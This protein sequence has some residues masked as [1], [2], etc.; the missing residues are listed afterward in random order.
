MR[1]KQTEQFSH[2][3]CGSS[4]TWMDELIAKKIHIT[5]RRSPSSFDASLSARDSVHTCEVTLDNR[6]NNHSGY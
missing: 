6:S 4:K 2:F 3:T 5:I 1:K